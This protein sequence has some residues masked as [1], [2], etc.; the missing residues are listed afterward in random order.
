MNTTIYLLIPLLILSK[1]GVSMKKIYNEF[2]LMLQFLTRI[3]VNR[4]L[5]CERDN[6]KRGSVFLPMIGLIIGGIQLLVYYIFY[7]FLPSGV[8]SVLIILA[9]IL[10]TGGLHIDGLGDTSDGFFAFKGKDRIVE[11][12][13]DS[14]IG[15]FACIAIVLDI[16]MRYSL[17]SYVIDK[18]SPLIII[19]AVVIGRFNI[20]LIS[21]I[22]KNAK[23]TGSGNLFI[24]NIDKL[25]LIISF[26]LT[27]AISFLFIGLKSTFI[28]LPL[29]LFITAL[30]NKYCVSKIGGITGDLLGA[31]NELCEI[32]ALIIFCALLR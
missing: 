23:S 13:K 4:S 11:I 8:V 32:A 14:R 31:N 9:G 6:F 18:A 21:F 29:T 20:M 3:P 30:F 24:G 12:M 25:Q 28:I 19:V 17:I 26:L 2:L 7:R 27:V 10:L 16:L 1:K 15:T 5:P 22:G